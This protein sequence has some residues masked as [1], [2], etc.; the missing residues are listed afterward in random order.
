MIRKKVTNKKYFK[1]CH[2]YIRY[3]PVTVGCSFLKIDE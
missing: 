3:A 1:N 2:F